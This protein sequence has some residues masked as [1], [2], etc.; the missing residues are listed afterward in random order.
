MIDLIVMDME[1]QSETE[2]SRILSNVKLYLDS[3]INNGRC[4]IYKTYMG[5]LVFH[6]TNFS[7]N[8]NFKC[9]K[10]WWYKEQTTL[11]K[12]RSRDA[13]IFVTFLDYS[14]IN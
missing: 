6:Q 10:E 2:K 8:R 1:C 11:I 4:L 5:V 14:I 13:K 12:M 9:G 7:N 3:L